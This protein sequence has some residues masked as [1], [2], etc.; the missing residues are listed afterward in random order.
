M[1]FGTPFWLVA[2][3]LGLAAL[4]GLWFASD[5]RAQ[6]RLHGAFPTPLLAHLL[7]SVHPGRR[8]VRRGLAALGAAALMLALARPQWGRN[9]IEIRLPSLARPAEMARPRP[10]P[11]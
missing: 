6:R 9:E 10:V 1:S 11:S 4:A 7:R 3:P 8:R 2:L 5:R